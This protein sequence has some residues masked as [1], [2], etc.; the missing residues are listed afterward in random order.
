MEHYDVITIGAGGACY[1]AAFRL[2]QSGYSVLMVD[3]KGVLSGNCLS[4]GCVPSKTIIE[5]VHNYARVKKFYSFNIDYEKII[6]RKDSVQKIRYAN[7]DRE[8]KNSGV[9]LLKGAASIVD[10]HTVKV[11]ADGVEKLYSADYIIIGTGTDTFVPDIPGKEYAY[12]SGDI[13]RINPS[14][15]KIPDSVVI[16]GGGYIGLETASFLSILGSRVKLVEVK[17]RILI[18]MDKEIIDKLYPLLPEMDVYFNNEVKS[19]EKVNER[20]KVNLLQDNGNRESIYADAV[21]M[22]TGREPV[23]PDGLDKIGI[24]YDRHG[25]K[26]NSGMQTNIKNIYATG[27]VNGITP[28]FHAA[29]RQSLVA[30]HN[31]MS[32]GKLTDYYDPLSVPYTLYTIPQ[33][34]YVGITPEYAIRNN[35]EYT[36]VKYDLKEDTLAEAFDEMYGEITLLVDKRMKIIGGYAIGND[37][38]NVINEIAFAVK[39]GLTARDFAEMAHQHPMTFEGLDTAARKLF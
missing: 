13:F 19:I 21:I 29:K 18:D 5:N 28:L 32:D 8:I 23:L 17:D 2:D 1:P 14:F 36:E 7:H 27:D 9:T 38:G 35:I 15:R 39:N 20:Y 3:K 25:I 4:E 30:A 34:S 26:V 33:M 22:A 24:V 31:I 10:E 11:N 37:A 6:E 12:V 16:I